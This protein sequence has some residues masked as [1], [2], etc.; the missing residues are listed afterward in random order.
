MKGYIVKMIKENNI[1]FG[2]TLERCKMEDF[3]M[4]MPVKDFC[5]L[6]GLEYDEE[7]NMIILFEVE[8]KNE[9][10]NS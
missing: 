2:M 6:T 3:R 9:I 10:A 4:R 5:K 7:D 8:E 1:H